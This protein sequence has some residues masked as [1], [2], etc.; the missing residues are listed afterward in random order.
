MSEDIPK[1]D[2][3]FSVKEITVKLDKLNAEDALYM[4]R[5]LSTKNKM[6]LHLYFR[7]MLF[8]PFSVN[9]ELRK[10]QLEAIPYVVKLIKLSEKFNQRDGWWEK[11]QCPLTHE[12][13]P[14]NNIPTKLIVKKGEIKIIDV[15]KSP[16]K[17]LLEFMNSGKYEGNAEYFAET[18][19]EDILKA[20]IFLKRI[21]WNRLE[22]SELRK[23]Y[24]LKKVLT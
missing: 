11:N 10:Q 19:K 15:N 17:Y 6:I 14:H 13:S 7:N 2:P 12:R 4:L 20:G 23:N 5:F 22:S 3:I 1:R 21:E 9:D 8:Y 16:G 24:N 18:Y